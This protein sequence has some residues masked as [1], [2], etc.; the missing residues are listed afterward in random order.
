MTENTGPYSRLGCGVGHK[1]MPQ[2]SPSASLAWVH[3][4]VDALVGPGPAVG[5]DRGLQVD[6]KHVWL[7]RPDVL[8]ATGWRGQQGRGVLPI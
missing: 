7:A 6:Q 4:V 1:P 8:W 3:A 5:G 2:P